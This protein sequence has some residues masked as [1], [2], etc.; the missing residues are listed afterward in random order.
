MNRHSINEN[1]S[2]QKI[3]NSIKFISFFFYNFI[4]ILNIII[5]II[6]GIRIRIWVLSLGY[7]KYNLWLNCEANDKKWAIWLIVLR[8]GMVAQKILTPFLVTC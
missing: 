7:R 1:N 3:I 5:I 8:S 4:S 2:F 6:G